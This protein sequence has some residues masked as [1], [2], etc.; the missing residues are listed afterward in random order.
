MEQIRSQRWFVRENPFG[1][2]G[3]CKDPHRLIE[4]LNRVADDGDTLVAQATP[5]F[6]YSQPDFMVADQVEDKPIVSFSQPAFARFG[7]VNATQ[8]QTQA[9][10]TQHEARLT[11]E[12]LTRVF[13]QGTTVDTMTRISEALLRMAT[14]FRSTNAKLT[15]SAIDK[16]KCPLKGEIRVQQLQH[17]SQDLIQLVQFRRS[18]GDPIEFKRFF[19]AVLQEA[20]SGASQASQMSIDG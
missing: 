20:F 13:I 15:F 17:P 14:Q 10:N 9:N 11:A 8:Q 18:K 7:D 19:K 16:R 3:R 1:N 12:R 2:N 6:A 4:A 5:A